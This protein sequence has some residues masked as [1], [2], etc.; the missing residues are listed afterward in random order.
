MAVTQPV[1]LAC[2]L[3]NQSERKSSQVSACKAW[4][5]QPQVDQV[6]IFA[7]TCDS[8]WSDQTISGYTK[9]WLR[10]YPLPF[11][12]NACSSWTW[13]FKFQIWAEVLL[14]LWHSL[15]SFLFAQFLGRFLIPSV[16][17]ILPPC[18]LSNVDEQGLVSRNISAWRL[19]PKQS[20][21]QHGGHGEIGEDWRR[22]PSECSRFDWICTIPHSTCTI[23]VYFYTGLQW[24]ATFTFKRGFSPRNLGDI[25]AYVRFTA[26]TFSLD[27]NDKILL[28][29]FCFVFLSFF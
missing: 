19:L 17:Q 7:S 29:F 5:T 27:L 21:K 4:Q 13:P 9:H 26:S 8:V 6:S 23:I 1:W 28:L 20:D 14:M 10:I 11:F 12:Q 24:V 18:L 22:R 25:Y 3:L 2:K 15:L 16:L